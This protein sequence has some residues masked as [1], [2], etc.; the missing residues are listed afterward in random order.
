MPHAVVGSPTFPIKRIVLFRSSRMRKM[1]GLFAMNMSGT[2]LL[3][4]STVVAAAA[5]VPSSLTSM[6]AL[7]FTLLR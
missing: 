6:N 4:V 2:L 1:N 3:T 5:S 7:C